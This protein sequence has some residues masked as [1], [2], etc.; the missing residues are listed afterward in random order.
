MFETLAPL[1]SSESREL[2]QTLHGMSRS[3]RLLRDQTTKLLPS[4]PAQPSSEQH[5][6]GDEALQGE[7]DSLVTETGEFMSSLPKPTY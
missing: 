7:L 5:H 3:L 6:A 2:V 4:C 1:I